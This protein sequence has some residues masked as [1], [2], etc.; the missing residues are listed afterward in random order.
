MH[1]IRFGA[2]GEEQPGIWLNASSEICTQVSGNKQAPKSGKSA[3]PMILDV[4]AMAFDIEDYNEHFFSHDGLARLANLLLEHDRKLIPVDGIRL[5]PPIARPSKIICVGGNY[6]G[7]I[8]E[9]KAD[10][11]ESP[12]LFSKAAT[13]VTGPFDPVVLPKN[14]KVV[15]GEAEL[16]VVIGKRTR[17]VSSEEAMEA[18]AGYMVLNDVSDRE[19]Q[20]SGSQWF[21]GKSP[22][23]FC[24]MGP[25]LVTKEEIEHPHKLRIIEKINGAVL[26]DGNTADMIFNIPFLISLISQS[27][28]LLPGDVISTGTPAGI[29]SARKPPI[30]LKPG[31]TLETIVEHVGHQI[32][33]VVV[34]S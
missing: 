32:N 6:L 9:S 27:I 13:A 23:T 2:P 31:D 1:L 5:A 29:G 19:V 10:I 4:R 12:V 16:A 11:P 14:A 20:H 3:K 24:P 18:V 21:R 22:D 30:L 25:F 33:K 34:G 17:N 26:Q 15:D 7:H 28:T 8:R